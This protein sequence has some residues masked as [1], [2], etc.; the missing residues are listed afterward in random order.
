MPETAMLVGCQVGLASQEWDTQW[1]WIKLWWLFH[2]IILKCIFIGRFKP[3]T[4]TPIETLNIILSVH[5][6][7]VGVEPENIIVVA[8]HHLSVKYNYSLT[9][10]IFVTKFFYLC[11]G[12]TEDDLWGVICFPNQGDRQVGPLFSAHA[13][14][15]VLVLWRH[16]ENTPWWGSSR[17]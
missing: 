14:A 6:R 2:A 15:D 1:H 11:P 10:C 17:F 7:C 9:F 5:K 12:I 16:L 8:R 13:D 3:M 4:T